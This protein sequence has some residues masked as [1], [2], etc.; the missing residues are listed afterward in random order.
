[1]AGSRLLPHRACPLAA[2]LWPLHEAIWDYVAGKLLHVPVPGVRL[3]RIMVVVIPVE[4]ADQLKED[5]S[6]FADESL[7]DEDANLSESQG[8][9]GKT[10][11]YVGGT[12]PQDE[13]SEEEARAT[14]RRPFYFGSRIPREELP[15]DDDTPCVRPKTPLSSAEPIVFVENILRNLRQSALNAQAKATQVKLVHKTIP[16]GPYELAVLPTAGGRIRSSVRSVLQGMPQGKQIEVFTPPAI[17]GQPASRTAIAIWIY[18]DAS[19]A[20]V[21]LDFQYKERFILWHAPDAHHFN[22]DYA[23]ELKHRLSTLNL[24]V[25]DKLDCTLSKK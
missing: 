23:E 11:F 21:H 1:M 25:P 3:D 17:E 4:V 2:H 15:D 10:P 16:V 8:G 7:L 18:E 14:K 12:I 6:A 5:L 13:T 20:V 19:M 9:E 24:E 22:F